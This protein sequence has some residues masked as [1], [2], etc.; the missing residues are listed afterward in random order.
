MLLGDRRIFQQVAFA[1]CHLFVETLG[2]SIH[3]LEDRRGSEKLECA[4][5]SKALVAT[6]LETPPRRSIERLNPEPPALTLLERSKALRSVA[7]SRAHNTRGSLAAASGTRTR[8]RTA[9][10]LTGSRQRNP[11]PARNRGRPN[12]QSTSTHLNFHIASL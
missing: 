4:A 5:H 12:Q 3:A 10:G 9:S 6:M 7:A 8:D 2:P 11:P 1:V